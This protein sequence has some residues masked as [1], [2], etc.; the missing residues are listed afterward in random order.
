VPPH[1]YGGK[2]IPQIISLNLTENSS[3]QTQYYNVGALVF[4][5][6]PGLDLPILYQFKVIRNL[7]VYKLWKYEYEI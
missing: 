5:L 3:E 7:N 2:W 1:L 6:Q 4:E